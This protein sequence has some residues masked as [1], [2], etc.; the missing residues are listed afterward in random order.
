MRHFKLDVNSLTVDD[1]RENP[2]WEFGNFSGNSECEVM[3]VYSLPCADM[4][5]RIVGTEFRLADGS[6]CWGILGG[7]SPNCPELGE[8][9]MSLSL[10]HNGNWFHLARPHQFN[11]ASHGPEQLARF[12]DKPVDRIFPISFNISHSVVGKPA[13]VRG[14]INQFPSERLTLQ[15]IL[16]M[17]MRSY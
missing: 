10:L 12:L 5:G 3:P 16:E 17:A 8:H 4:T 13:S 6:T 2:V 7:V 14:Q 1:L 9:L 11:Y 15:E